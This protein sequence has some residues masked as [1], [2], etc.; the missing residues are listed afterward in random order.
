MKQFRLLLLVSTLFYG[1]LANYAQED[2]LIK[3]FSGER[4]KA[5][6]AVIKNSKKY[7]KDGMGCTEFEIS[8]PKAGNYYVNF[9][10]IPTQELT[11]EPSNYAVEVNGTTSVKK[12]I[13][14]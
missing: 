11:G 1:T 5:G 6:E 9:W 3:Q 2:V 12:V 4:S 13:I 8:V 14:N 7:P 10:M